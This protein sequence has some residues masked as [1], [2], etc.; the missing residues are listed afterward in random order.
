MV[1]ECSENVDENEIIY[2]GT[3]NAI[4]LNDYKKVCGSCT[5]YIVLFAVFLVTNTV[6]STVF[7]YFHWYLKKMLPMHITNINDKFQK[8]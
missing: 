3:L 7:I 4:P 1:E 8:N 2:N 5:L 6:I